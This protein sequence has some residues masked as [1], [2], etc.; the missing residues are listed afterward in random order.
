MQS[1]YRDT[2][3]HREMRI[4]YKEMQNRNKKIL[5]NYTV[6]VSCPYVAEV[7]KAPVSH[8]PPMPSTA[9]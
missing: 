1:N 3:N 2:Q 9:F 6:C 5:N 8:N 4:N 7:I